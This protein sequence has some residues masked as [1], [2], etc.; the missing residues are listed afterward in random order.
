LGPIFGPQFHHHREGQPPPAE[1]PITAS[2]GIELLVR[3]VLVAPAVG[4]PRAEPRAGHLQAEL[5]PEIP[6]GVAGASLHRALDVAQLGLYAGLDGLT[7]VAVSFMPSV[8]SV[9]ERASADRV[10]LVSERPL[11]SPL[12]EVDRINDAF[13]WYFWSCP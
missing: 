2:R 7:I 5:G 12:A 13:S 3:V 9:E 4:E 6:A 8:Q 1:G 10:M 11:R